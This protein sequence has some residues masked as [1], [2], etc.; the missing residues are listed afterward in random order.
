MLRS[1]WVVCAASLLAINFIARAD[2]LDPYDALANWNNLPL[3]KTGVTAGLFSSVDLNSSDPN[4]TYNDSGNYAGYNNTGSQIVID[5]NTG[6]YVV[7]ALSGPGEITRFW[8]PHA[9]ANSAGTV[10]IFLDV[11][12]ADPNATLNSTP[13]VNS[14]TASLLVNSSLSASTP[15]GSPLVRDL[16]GGAASYQPIAFQQSALIE[17]SNIGYY[18]VGY[19]LFSAGTTIPTY[20]ASAAPSPSLATV[21]NMLLNVGSN[22]V[23]PTTTAPSL[24]GSVNAGGSATI[25]SLTGSGQIGALKLQVAPGFTPTNAQLDGLYLRISYNGNSAYAVNVPVSQ[26]FGVGHGRSAYQSLPMG[27]NN[28]GSYYCYFPMPFANGAS[29]QLF[30]STGSSIPVAASVQYTPGTVPANANYFHAVYQSQTTASG[31]ASYNLLHI[32]GS[33]HYVGNM[34]SITNG[35]T[36]PT[37]EGNDIVT[38]DGKSV[39]EGTGVEDAYNGGYYYNSIAGVAVTDHGDTPN[40]S[41]GA[42][43]YSGVLA[44]NPNDASVEKTQYRWLIGDYVPF[45]QSLDVSLQNAGGTNGVGYDSTAFYYSSDAVPEPSG[46]MVVLGMGAMF[47]LRRRAA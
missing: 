25:A 19:H 14:D 38:V 37:M 36:F 42:T 43:P 15:S 28:D 41:S 12:L 4:A 1:S 6:L 23:T 10:K 13:A 9:N 39:M 44:F 47:L 33:G 26:F 30:N 27:V 45:T 34:L 24:N 7:G 31:Q 11:N 20:N 18:Q 35:G 29:V 40:Q 16:L 32:N 22:P 8:M 17:T 2:T 5:P 46:V 3:A 21:N